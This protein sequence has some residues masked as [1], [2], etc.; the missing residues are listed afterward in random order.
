MGDR[1][2]SQLLASMISVC[3]SGIEIQSVFQYLFLHRMPQTLRTLL[4]EQEFGDILALAALADS[5]WISH[6]PQP[7]KVMAVQEP[8]VEQQVAA[9]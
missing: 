3:P 9:V 6:K 1:K 8:A 7:I 5:L 2:P 4:G